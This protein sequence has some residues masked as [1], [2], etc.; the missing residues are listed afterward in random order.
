MGPR[1]GATFN[2]RA[3]TPELMDKAR[4]L[5]VVCRRHGVPL[6]AAALQ[7]IL[8]HPAIVSVIPGARSVAEARDNVA[9]VEYPIPAALWAE[10]KGERLIVETAPTPAG[11]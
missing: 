9:M 10:L 4:R 1:E 5:D 2:Y 3:A 7:F 6:K 8:A 11:A